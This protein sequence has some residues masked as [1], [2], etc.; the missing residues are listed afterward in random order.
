M[1]DIAYGISKGM[2]L[3]SILDLPITAYRLLTKAW[4][5]EDD[6]QRIM[7]A[8]A[9]FVAYTAPSGEALNKTLK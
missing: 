2:P 7:N 8:R 4:R 3:G 1:Q 5:S 9:G 6:A